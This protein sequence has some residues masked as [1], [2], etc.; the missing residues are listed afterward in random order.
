M[1]NIKYITKRTIPT[2][3][4]TV[5]ALSTYS[6]SAKQKN[7]ENTEKTNIIKTDSCTLEQYNDF[8]YLYKIQSY[9]YEKAKGTP[10]EMKGMDKSF[11]VKC[12]PKEFEKYT[13]EKNITWSDLKNTVNNSKFD[14]YHKN[15]LLNGINNLEKNNFNINLSAINYNIKNIDIEF[16]DNYDDQDLLGEFSC[17]D[18]KIKLSK[19]IYNQKKYEVVFLHEILGHGMTDAYIDE[20]KVYCSIDTPTYVTNQDNEIIGYSLYGEAFTESTAQIIAITALDK[21]LEPEY[22]C[23]YDLNMAELLM[24]CKDTNCEISEYANNGVNYLIQKMKN[25]KIDNPYDLIAMAT[26]NL[27]SVEMNQEIIKPAEQ[28]MYDYF[29]ERVSDKQE[30]GKTIEE[31]NND[32]KESFTIFGE[33]ILVLRNDNNDEMVVHNQDYINFTRL[34]NEIGNYAL[35]NNQSHKYVK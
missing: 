3:I 19:N 18:H 25:N 14:D 30:E 24:I 4:A 11:D 10:Y 6:C 13:N 8:P 35:E 5:T 17:F 29:C 26:Y 22:A 28:I 12:T 31:I 34:Y 20:T 15:I 9:D 27:E 21:Q 33:Y 16:V 2:M 23:G 32:I 7:N 1:I